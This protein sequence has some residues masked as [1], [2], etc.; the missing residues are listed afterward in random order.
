MDHIHVNLLHDSRY[1]NPIFYDQYH[2]R[3]LIVVGLL[4]NLHISSIFILFINRKTLDY[5][6]WS[7]Q[8]VLPSKYIYLYT[9]KI[10]TFVSKESEC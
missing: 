9:Q 2:R 1:D 7:T 8:A 4:S 6:L 10:T 5:Y 3:S